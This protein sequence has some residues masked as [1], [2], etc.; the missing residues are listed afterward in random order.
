MTRFP[1][2]L[3]QI[4]VFSFC[5]FVV[6]GC[7]MALQGGGTEGE[8]LWGT[9]VD[10]EGM[11]VADAW[12]MAYLVPDTLPA[13]AKGTAR[14]TPVDSARS[15]DN[16]KFHLKRLA[17][18]TYNLFAEARHRHVALSAFIRDIEY[19]TPNLYLGTDTLRAPGSIALQVTGEGE[20]LTNAS[21]H[22]E[23]SP[24]EAVSG[25]AG[26]C[27]LPGLPSGTYRIMASHPSFETALSGTITLAPGG[28]V[29]GFS[30]NLL[31]QAPTP[32]PDRHFTITSSTVAL[33]TFNAYNNAGFIPDQGPSGF[34]L[35]GH[36]IPLEASPYGQA[37]VFN[38]DGLRLSTPYNTAFTVAG[39][40]RITI[41]ARVYLSAYPGPENFN[42]ASEI[43]G[44]YPGPRLL[45]THDGGIKIS[46]QKLDASGTGYWYIPESAPHTMPLNRWVTLAFAL[47]TT[48]TPKQAYAYLDGVPIQMYEAANAAPFRIPEAALTVGNDG[49]DH[50]PLNGKIDEIRI[51]NTLLLGPG[52]PLV[53]KTPTSSRFEMTPQTVAL[54]RF[55]E[56]NEGEQIFDIGPHGFHLSPENTIPLEPSPFDSAAVFDGTN[57]IYTAAYNDNFNL[58]LTGQITYEARIFMSQYPAATNFKNRAT[59]IGMYA[60][61]ALQITSDGTI[62]IKAQGI[63]G[64][65]SYWYDTLSSLPGAVPLNKWV[66]VAFSINANTSPK[67]VYAYVDG[68]PVQLYGTPLAHE[69]RIYREAAFAIG[70][71][72]YDNQPFRGK[73]EEARVSNALVLGAGLPIMPKP[74][75][76]AFPLSVPR[77]P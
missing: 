3:F 35:S 45:I 34:H 47:D 69:F 46:M 11:P 62:N 76:I 31:P 21:C 40:G 43:V 1:R 9:F 64:G 8:G 52:L 56:R 20:P 29:T 22:I 28:V 17:Q 12:V 36:T 6:G 42:Q 19:T 7:N 5:M 16:G 44:F 30:L 71:D 26:T 53:E 41:E 15:D 38:G 25:P 10:S 23:N 33:W 57:K 54:W 59:V 49:Q 72:T 50:Q 48:V 55:T 61:P 51:S 70:N 60:G 63:D 2:K 4:A 73:I 65:T 58:G 24:W 77:S 74:A 27:A 18:G 68:M 39:T 13:M 67:Q 75:D 14:E 37:V 32:S 66:N